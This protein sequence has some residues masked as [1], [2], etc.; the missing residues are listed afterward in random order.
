MNDVNVHAISQLLS[1]M[2][3]IFSGWKTVDF[4]VSFGTIYDRYRLNSF[5]DA[6]ELMG[7]R[8]GPIV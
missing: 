4:S 7:L 1:E 8:C 3:R 2:S 6:I 5:E